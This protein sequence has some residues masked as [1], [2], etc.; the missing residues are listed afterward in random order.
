MG[1]RGGYSVRKA[2]S[3]IGLSKGT[4]TAKKKAETVARP[5]G[6]LG[7]GTDSGRAT[8][9]Q[10][11]AEFS[12][13]RKGLSESMVDAIASYTNGSYVSMNNAMRGKGST[14]PSEYT[15]KQVE[16]LKKSFNHSLSKK[17]TVYRGTG[18]T[19][20]ATLAEMTTVG[21]VFRDKG[22]FSTSLSRTFATSWASSKQNP[23]VFTVA[24]PSGF[25]GAAF[26]QSISPHKSE[27]EVLIRPGQNWKVVKE[28][29]PL[30]GGKIR[31]MLITPV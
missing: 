9:E 18:T 4:K 24:L 8:V 20:A 26:V 17:L 13:W 14:P 27:K 30:K 15:K 22:A 23:V 10:M 3:S 5:T 16:Q 12:S 19:N 1:G 25:K 31:H 21:A 28:L 2:L 11:L 29:K 6:N 7:G